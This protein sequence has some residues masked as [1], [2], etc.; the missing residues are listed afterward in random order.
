M[1]MEWD[2]SSYR[3]YL[4]RIFVFKKNIQLLLFLINIGYKLYHYNTKNLILIN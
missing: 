3:F 2:Y 4:K 1:I